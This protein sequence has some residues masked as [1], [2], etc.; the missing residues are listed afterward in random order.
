M[1]ISTRL[2]ARIKE[3]PIVLTR[4]QVNRDIDPD[5]WE[6]LEQGL[7]VDAYLT[8]EDDFFITPGEAWFVRPDTGEEWIALP[9]DFEEVYA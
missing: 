8:G 7:Q 4:I 9:G 6:L 2:E 5:I 3:R 1:G